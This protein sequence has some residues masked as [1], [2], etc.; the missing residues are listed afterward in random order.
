MS[1]GADEVLADLIAQRVGLR[2]MGGPTGWVTGCQAD[3]LID[4][5]GVLGR[6][7]PGA[8]DIEWQIP[9]ARRIRAGVLSVASRWGLIGDVPRS[10]LGVRCLW[11]VRCFG[12]LDCFGPTLGATLGSILGSI[13]GVFVKVTGWLLHADASW[14]SWTARVDVPARSDRAPCTPVCRASNALF[15]FSESIHSAD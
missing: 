2:V 3:G 11:G 12:L 1:L 10:A 6:I 14:S 13:L 9:Q 4:V 15:S 5:L 8:I 7:A